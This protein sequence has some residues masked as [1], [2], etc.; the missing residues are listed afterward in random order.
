[1]FYLRQLIKDL[2]Y[3]LSWNKRLAKLQKSLY[4]KNFSYSNKIRGDSKRN[5]RRID[6]ELA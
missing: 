1:M 2:M 4:I 5:R 3:A 6:S